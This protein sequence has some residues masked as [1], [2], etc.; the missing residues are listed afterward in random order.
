MMIRGYTIATRTIAM[1]V[2]AL[3][4][5]AVIGFGVTQ[6]QQRRNAASQARMG[7]AQGAG[8]ADSASNAIATVARA[9]EAAAASEELTRTNE[10]A[11]RAAPGADQRVDMGVQAA[12]LQALC[13]RAAYA[14][15]PRCAIFKEPR[16]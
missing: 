12:G 8:N 4:L 10:R 6:C 2:G 3:F 7:A 11:I 13:R 15:N 9:G 16:R 14:D 1:I 5:L